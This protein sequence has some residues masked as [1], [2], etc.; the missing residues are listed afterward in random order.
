MLC[1][2][3]M[4][5]E[6]LGNTTLY[7]WP[8][9]TNSQ[10]FTVQ[11]NIAISWMFTGVLKQALFAKM[12]SISV[13]HPLNLKH[14]LWHVIFLLQDTGGITWQDLFFDLGSSPHF[15]PTN[16]E[17]V[18]ATVYCFNDAMLRDNFHRSSQRKLKLTAQE[19]TSQCHAS[20]SG[21]KILLLE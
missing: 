20:R 15:L 3:I 17:N 12:S 8:S 7:Y 9:P 6:F 21:K 4:S 11:G 10:A 2:V 14:F 19:F 13:S 16:N 5:Q 18:Q 1:G